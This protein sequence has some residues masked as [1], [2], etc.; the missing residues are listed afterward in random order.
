MYIKI[1]VEIKINETI[2][3][4]ELKKGKYYLKLIK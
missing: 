2:F 3:F 4:L 1:D